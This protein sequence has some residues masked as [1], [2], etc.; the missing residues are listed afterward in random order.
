MF[1]KLWGN[2]RWLIYNWHEIQRQLIPCGNLFN[3]I[4]IP[5]IFLPAWSSEQ[6]VQICTKISLVSSRCSS[7]WILRS[8]IFLPKIALLC[9]CSVIIANWFCHH[10]SFTYALGNQHSAV[11]K[12]F[13]NKWKDK[14]E[15]KHSPICN[16]IL[17]KVCLLAEIKLTEHWFVGFKPILS[18]QRFNQNVFP[19][20]LLG[21][22]VAGTHKRYLWTDSP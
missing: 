12:V 17:N 21:C 19:G 6:Y 14:I 11:V 7:R 13:W 4:L 16:K 18:Q 22:S 15:I 1:K 10:I 5:F 20:S 2:P 8:W 3:N 9:L